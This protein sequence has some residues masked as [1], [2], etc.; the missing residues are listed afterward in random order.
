MITS[1]NLESSCGDKIVHP[2]QLAST[3]ASGT[4]STLVSKERNKF[5]SYVHSALIKSNTAYNCDLGGSYWAML[6]ACLISLRM[7]IAGL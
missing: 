5:D 2:N 7:P 6:V 4:G 3:E 1:I